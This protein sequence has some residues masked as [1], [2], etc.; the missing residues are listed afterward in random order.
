[1][2]ALRMA[3]VV[4]VILVMTTVV[5]VPHLILMAWGGPIASII[6]QF[7]HKVARRLLLIDIIIEGEPLTGEPVL[8]VSN[9]VSWLDI[10]VMGAALRASFVAK[11]EVGTWPV[12]SLLSNLQRSVY[13]SRDRKT[14]AKEQKIMQARLERGESLILF[15]EG[16]SNDGLRVGEF[17]SAFLS[18]ADLEVKGEKVKV[19][20][21]AIT[22]TKVDG[23]P[24]TRRSM[25][26]VAWYGDM[27]LAPHLKGV[28]A[29]GPYEVRL[30][31]F[32]PVTIDEIGNRKALARHC[33]DLIVRGNSEALSAG[34]V[35]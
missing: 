34:S 2:I 17:R 21:F 32:A 30:R 5:I 15:P 8:F 6:P 3:F 11:R 16:T 27:D 4:A 9:H 29:G 25:P 26:Q 33:R 31:F 22:Y 20:P 28:F 35:A 12:I 7:W 18:L 24:V 23:F 19:Q 1:M 10:V 13:V 14:A